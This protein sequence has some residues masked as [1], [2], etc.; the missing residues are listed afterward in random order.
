[1]L[2]VPPE[3]VSSEVVAVVAVELDAELPEPVPIVMSLVLDIVVDAIVVPVVI[4]EV[5]L[6]DALPVPVLVSPD[7]SS[8]VHP[9]IARPTSAEISAGAALTTTGSGA[10]QNGQTRSDPQ[11]WRAQSGQR[12]IV[13]PYHA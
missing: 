13:G 2:P 4:A 8:P 1:V 5:E 10:V 9:N 3:S 12:Y 6:I 11:T 7:M